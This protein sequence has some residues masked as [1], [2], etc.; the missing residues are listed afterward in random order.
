M[1]PQVLVDGLLASGDL[2]ELVP[3]QSLDVPLYWQHWRVE[4]Q[5]LGALTGAV[6]AAA[7]AMLE[8]G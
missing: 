2:V 4:S 5:A 7:A 3:G 6:H 8:R 1:N